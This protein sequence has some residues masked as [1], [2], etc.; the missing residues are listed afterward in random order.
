MKLTDQILSL[1]NI[2]TLLLGGGHPKLPR[3]ASNGPIKNDIFP[4]SDFTFRQTKSLLLSLY[5]ENEY[6]LVILTIFALAL[7]DLIFIPDCFMA[8]FAIKPGSK[9]KCYRSRQKNFFSYHLFTSSAD[10]AMKKPTML[11]TILLCLL[12]F[13][14]EYLKVL[15]L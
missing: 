4:N 12:E 9:L 7:F 14:Y 8:G 2:L 5:L 1:L 15:F 3:K 13:S 6:K 11:A 10:W